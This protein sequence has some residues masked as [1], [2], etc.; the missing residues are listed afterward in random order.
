MNIIW[1]DEL[2]R[3]DGARKI[4]EMIFVKVL[5]GRKPSILSWHVEAR[6]EV[7]KNGEET[8]FGGIMG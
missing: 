4:E 5:E 1:R 3:G 8:V 2:F 6:N 7:K